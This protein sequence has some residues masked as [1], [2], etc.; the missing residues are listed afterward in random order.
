MPGLQTKYI[1]GNANI[2]ILNAAGTQ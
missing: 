2:C 1:N